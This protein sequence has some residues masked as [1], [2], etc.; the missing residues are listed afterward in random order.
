MPQ[1]SFPHRERQADLRA[2]VSELCAKYDAAYW[3][4]Q[5]REH[6]FPT[7]F[8]REFVDAGYMGA[9]IPEE[10]GGGGGSMADMSAI[11]EEVAASGG[12][13]N[14][15]SSIHIPL[16]CVPA[17][18]SFGTEEQKQEFLPKVAR[19]ELFV[20]FGVT[21]PTAGTDTIRI[22]TR[23]TRVDGGYLINGAKVWNSGAV[24]GDKILF[25]ARTSAPGEAGGR[26]GTGLTLFMTD[27]QVPTIDIRPIPKMVRNAVESCEVFFA[28]TFVAD[29]EVIG[30]VDEGFYH[31]LHSL[32]GERLLIASEALGLGR[33]A[34]E[35]ASR[36]ANER[37]VFDRPIGMNQSVA[38]PLAKS[39]LQ[40]LAGAEMLTRAIDVYATQ[41]PAAAGLLSNAAKYL[42]SEA[43]FDATDAAMQT[44]GGYSFAREYHIGRF[45]TEARL[46]RVG[47]VNNQMVLNYVAERALALPRSY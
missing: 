22:T 30:R 8:V 34:I 32:N 36:Y 18:L 45:W 31:M 29:H 46:F 11:V 3:E 39:Y 47:P 43:A 27:L 19:G 6:T 17:L 28:D 4:R 9:F 26:R 15:T 16:L 41:G 14:A 5:D 1:V 2:A 20:T 33:W 25:L 23:A 42:I 24:R 40:L 35:N 37:I 21:E 7:D 10:Y 44:F 13:L 12:G 38:H